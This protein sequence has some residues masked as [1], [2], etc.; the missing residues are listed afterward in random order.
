MKI[1]NIDREFLHL[2]NDL[3]K[4]NKTFNKDVF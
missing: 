2:L 1:A 3:R 4:F